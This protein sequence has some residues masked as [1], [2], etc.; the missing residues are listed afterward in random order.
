M[1][2]STRIFPA[3]RRNICQEIDALRVKVAGD[4]PISTEDFKHL[5]GTY[6]IDDESSL[7]YVVNRIVVR[8][9]LIVAYR[10]LATAGKATTKDTTPIHIADVELKSGIRNR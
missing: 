8:Q 4:A 2:C 3:A 9:G 7:L 10:S 6:H 5:I 1:S